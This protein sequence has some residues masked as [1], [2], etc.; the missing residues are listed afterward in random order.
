MQRPELHEHEEQEDDNG[1]SRV[2]EVLPEVP[3]ASAAQGN[4]VNW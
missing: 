4:Q 1:A 3:Q 2:E